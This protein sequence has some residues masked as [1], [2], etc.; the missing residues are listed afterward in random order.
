MKTLIEVEIYG[1]TF[2]VTSEDE[3]AYVR[4]LAAYV[5][6]AIRQAGEHNKTNVQLRAAIMAALGIADEYYKAIRREE[7][8]RQEADRLAATILKRLEQCEPVRAGGTTEPFISVASS[9]L[10]LDTVEN[11]K[12]KDTLSPS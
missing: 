10:P 12:K 4:S 9:N 5:D 11:E 2:T 1:Q 7:E 6:R 3:V 8:V